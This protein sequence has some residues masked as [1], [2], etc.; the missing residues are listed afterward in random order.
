MTALRGTAA[1]GLY[2]KK[3][4]DLRLKLQT[5]LIDLKK[6]VKL[7]NIFRIDVEM[8]VDFFMKL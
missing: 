8:F 6:K 1:S 2:Q 7:L 3:K 5:K 4:N